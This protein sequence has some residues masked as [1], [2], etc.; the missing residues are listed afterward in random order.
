MRSQILCCLVAAA[1]GSP[2]PSGGLAFQHPTDVL[3][4]AAYFDG[5]GGLPD[6]SFSISVVARVSGFRTSN[7]AVLVMSDWDLIVWLDPAPTG[8]ARV[9]VVLDN[10]NVLT[11][12][13]SAPGSLGGGFAYD[14]W[15]RYTLTYDKPSD[16]LAFY[17]CTV[18]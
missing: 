14:A 5:G 6:G 15:H 7:R 9:T 4:V 3:G 16:A 2:A 17:V 1:A 8:A 10:A 12:A 13:A 11:N 18:S